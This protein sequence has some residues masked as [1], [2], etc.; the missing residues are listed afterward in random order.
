MER[1]NKIEI[2]QAILESLM[3][4]WMTSP[5]I[6]IVMNKI[7]DKV[8]LLLFECSENKDYEYTTSIDQLDFN[9]DKELNNSIIIWLQQDYWIL[10][11]W[12][13]L[14]FDIDKAVSWLKGLYFYTSPLFIKLVK[15]K[16]IEL[17]L[18]FKK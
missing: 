17:K 4:S 15:E 16:I 5:E 2:Y 3:E 8:D 10:T 13:L 7:R 18:H 14:D 11:V 1:E 12:E 6:H 9:D